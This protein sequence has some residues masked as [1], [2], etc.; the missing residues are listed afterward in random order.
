MISEEFLIF[1]SSLKNTTEYYRNV[2]LL[3]L[4]NGILFACTLR[5]LV[6]VNY[7]QTLDI[8]VNILSQIY[9]YISKY[10]T[11]FS[12]VFATNIS[13]PLHISLNQSLATQFSRHILSKLFDLSFHISAVSKSP[14]LCFVCHVTFQLYI[15]V[16][17]YKLYLNT[18]LETTSQW[19]REV[20]Q[21]HMQT[22]SPTHSGIELMY[23]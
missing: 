9:S 6:C 23:N 17:T 19:S 14:M 13:Y 4:L 22:K 12:C 2:L 21:G 7:V 8:Y 18:Y 10:F 5:A 3:I 11:N 1:S 16:S 20:S 15:R